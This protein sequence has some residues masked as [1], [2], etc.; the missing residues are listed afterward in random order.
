MPDAT[1]VVVVDVVAVLVEVAALPEPVPPL[2]EDRGETG[3]AAVGP[4]AG[5]RGRR[6]EEVEAQRPGQRPR[7][8]GDP[9]GPELAIGVGFGPDRVAAARVEERNRGAVTLGDPALGQELRRAV[10]ARVAP[11]GP[12]LD[13]PP[14][15]VE[16]DGVPSTQPD[17]VLPGPGVPVGGQPQ[18]LAVRLELDH[19]VVGSDQA[20]PEPGLPPAAHPHSQAHPVRAAADQPC[21]YR[22]LG[23]GE[24]LVGDH[25]L[26]ELDEEIADPAVGNPEAQLAQQPR[27]PPADGHRERPQDDLDAEQTVLEYDLVGGRRSASRHGRRTDTS[28]TRSSPK[29][30]RL[31]PPCSR[32]PGFAAES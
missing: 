14:G 7:R 22:M 17:E 18:R 2:R 29:R 5:G 15:L 19:Q 10:G 26:G 4:Q 31:S 1:V 8:D 12:E 13:A 9:L 20:D 28:N 32:T 6:A 16:G 21:P 25:P 23:E 11:V 30:H 27:A 3:Q 24:V